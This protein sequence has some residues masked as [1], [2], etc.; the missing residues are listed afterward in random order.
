MTARP[1]L[2][3]ES[4]ATDGT[5]TVQHLTASRDIRAVLT[6]RGAAHAPA[7]VV[8]GRWSR[9]RRAA[10]LPGRV[11]VIAGRKVGNA[12]TRNRAKRRIRAALRDV[13]VPAGLDVVVIA[14]GPAT[15]A[16]YPELVE[17]VSTG[18]GRF[19]GPRRSQGKPGG[20]GGRRL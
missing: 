2:A 11:A 1:S 6:A 9:E 12:V 17:Q 3:T 14:R 4:P 20:P 13:H 10:G 7:L 15:S 8:R 5:L 18:I 16:P 19:T